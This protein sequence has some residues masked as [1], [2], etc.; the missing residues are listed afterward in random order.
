M[1]K[2]LLSLVLA[3][4]MVASTSVS[5]FADD[6][7]TISSYK[8]G[9]N[10]ANVNINGAVDANN[11]DSPS[12]TISV[13]IPTA[14]S[15]S[16]NKNGEVKGGNITITNRGVETVD[17]TAVSFQDTTSRRNITVK[18]PTDLNENDDTRANI[19]LSIG[20]TTGGIAYFKSEDAGSN[21]NGIYNAEG[22]NEENGIRLS[23]IPGNGKSETLSLAGFAGKQDLT[24]DETNKGVTDKFILT[25]KVTKAT[26]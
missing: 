13:S 11:G 10:T 25:L 14:L 20:G 4:A 17:V 9:S 12:G 18:S 23:S 3:G 2:K 24:N 5:A 22:N 19:V 21:K 26:S 16:V 6:T 1:K 8:E 7:T 15:F